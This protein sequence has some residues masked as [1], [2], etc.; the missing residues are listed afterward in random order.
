[1]R[2][3]EKHRPQT[4]DD[5]LGQPAIGPLKQ[6]VAEPYPS[7]FL[8]EGPS[9]TGKTATA[10]ILQQALAAQDFL[11]GSAYDVRGAKLTADVAAL[12]F[13]RA[14]TPFRFVVPAGKF[15]VL[16]IE[17][18]ERLHPAVQNDLKESLEEAQ[19][20][21]RVI[22]VATSNDSS[23]LETALRDR[24]QT[25]YFS[26]G[27][28]FAQAVNDWLPSVWTEEIGPDVEMP[29]GYA[30]FGWEGEQFS[31]RRALDRLEKY[32]MLQRQRRSM[33]AVA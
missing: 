28:S 1:M 32:I 29:Y 10:M 14:T 21:R 7:I 18:L 2:L 20:D 3:Y 12:Y 15:H 11:G 9:G 25:Y 13:D 16:R 5:V 23:R 8:L 19:R 33:E 31:A 22:I 17:E 27:P 26:A 6:F 4:L 30:D 24:F